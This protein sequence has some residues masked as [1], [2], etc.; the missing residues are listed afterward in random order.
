MKVL[1]IEDDISLA[2][3]V[4]NY[5]KL[6]GFEV[7]HA[8]NGA[9]GI[10]MAFEME[11]DAIV[12]DINIPVIDGYQVFKVL[13]ETQTKLTVPFI[14]LTAK[15]DL[16]EIREGMK[17]GADDYITKPFDFNDLYSSIITRIE[18]QQ[19]L[20]KTNED[21]FL[22]L[23]NNSEHGAFICSK[24]KFAL[25]NQKMT[26]LFGYSQIEL[27]Q[28]NLIDLA[29]SESKQ[30]IEKTV[31]RC[32][33][34]RQ[35]EVTVEFTAVH[36]RLKPLKLKLVAGFSNYNSHPCVVGYLVNLTGDSYHLK[37]VALSKKDLFDLGRA[38]EIF[39]TDY[40]FISK[41]LVNKLTNVFKQEKSKADQNPQFIELTVREKEVL[42]EICLGKSTPEIAESLF[43]SERTVEKHRAAIISKTNSKNMIEAVIVAIR[44]DL[45]DL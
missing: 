18:K 31:S 23:L 42:G 43:I 21:K 27:E 9:S 7:F 36:K 35:K 16:Q 8:N 11:P 29:D 25:V 4:R 3:T 37:D 41:D 6:K 20:L 32:I 19:R 22:T 39:S 1:L 28:K 33:S 26:T 17:L 5:L 15:T 12:C 45:V 24:D 30:L 10:Q 13:N 14:F 2:G 34:E 38:I 44:N 40:D